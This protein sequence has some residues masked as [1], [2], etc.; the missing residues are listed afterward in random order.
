VAV[1][2]FGYFYMDDDSWWSALGRLAAPCFFF[3][4]GY[5]HT[6]TV[7]LRWLWLGIFLTLLESWNAGWTWV[8]PNILLSFIFIRLVRPYVEMLVRSYGWFA[9]VGLVGALLALLPIVDPFVDYGSEG[10]MWA[11]FGFC[12]RLYVD[13]KEAA[14]GAD[15][16]GITDR[17]PQTLP[18][19]AN[20]PGLVTGSVTAGVYIWQEQRV[21]QFSDMQF[22]IVVIGISILA[23]LLF[24]YRRGRC[25]FQPS[26]FLSVPLTF[27]G[28][29]TLEIYAIQLA[30]SELL[31]LF[32]PNLAP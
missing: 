11:L 10:W 22:A 17:P 32:F 9:I 4:L 13:R 5:A 19:T 7:P 25:P 26:E 12:Q 27:I 21:Y 23:V 29:H 2:H 14:F 28:R 31:V 24:L 15:K 18:P 1:D 6:R 3:L 16:P 20:L 30:G 8:A